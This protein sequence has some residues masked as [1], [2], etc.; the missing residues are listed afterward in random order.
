MNVKRETWNDFEYFLI[1][2]GISIG[3]GCIWRFPFLL[4]D[5]GGAAFLIPYIFFLITLVFPLI[6]L[7]IGVG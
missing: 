4:Y 7:E 2:I 6:N 1:N 5:N 3:L